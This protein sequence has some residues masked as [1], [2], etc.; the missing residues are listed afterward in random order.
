MS[1]IEVCIVMY[2]MILSQ[3][4]PKINTYNEMSIL[5]EGFIY[6]LM[7]SKDFDSNDAI[8]LKLELVKIKEDKFGDLR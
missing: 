8:A 4:T 7:R 3:I 6:G 1:K 5:E 2:K